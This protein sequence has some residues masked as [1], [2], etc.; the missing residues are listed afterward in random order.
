MFSFDYG[1][2]FINYSYPFFGS[3]NIFA[4][5]SNYYFPSIFNMP[6]LGSYIYSYP[7]FGMSFGTNT[8]FQDIFMNSYFSP[9]SYYYWLL[10]YFA[11]L[12]GVPVLSKIAVKNTPKIKRRF[13]NRRLP[14]LNK[15]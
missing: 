1:N 8:T 4:P 9:Y 15:Y 2:L 12:C 11:V 10:S 7:Y 13:K 3:T 14:V 6:S 5:Y